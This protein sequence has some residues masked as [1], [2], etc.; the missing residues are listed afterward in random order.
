MIKLIAAALLGVGLLTAAPAQGNPPPSDE[1]IQYAVDHERRICTDLAD[2]PTVA[3][4]ADI[5]TAV[6]KFGGLTDY[7]SGQAVALAVMDA[8]PQYTAVLLRF[9]NVYG[10]TGASYFEGPG[11]RV[12][13]KGHLGGVIR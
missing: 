8:C 6:S 11:G 10:V 12:Y 13:M 7:E 3:R 9:A 4:V 5:M 1:V 2:N